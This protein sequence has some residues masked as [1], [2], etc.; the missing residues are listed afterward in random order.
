MLLQESD[1][2]GEDSV[3]QV[4]LFSFSFSLRF[5]KLGGKKVK[6]NN[7]AELIGK[8]GLFMVRA[9]PPFFLANQEAFLSWIF[10]FRHFLDLLVARLD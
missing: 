10:N 4:F 3:L 8:A 2:E 5:P 1:D 7:M 9:S 6:L